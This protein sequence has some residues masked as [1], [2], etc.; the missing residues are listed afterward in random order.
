MFPNWGN[1]L[2]GRVYVKMGSFKKALEV[3]EDSQ[4]YWK[5]FAYMGVGRKD[6]AFKLAHQLLEFWENRSE[7]EYIR[8]DS[9]AYVHFAIEEFDEVIEALE[10]GYQDRHPSLLDF[11]ADPLIDNFR[12][13]ER[14]KNL[15][16]RMNL[17]QWSE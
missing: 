8:S 1:E 9:F 14:F 15:L 12:K 10:K 6:D 5:I 13:N 3:M 17:E 2:L 7:H 16:K 4:S 11:F